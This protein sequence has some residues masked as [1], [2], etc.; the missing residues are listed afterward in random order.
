MA[1]VDIKARL[2]DSAVQRIWALAVF[3]ASAESMA[4]EVVAYQA[5][6]G[7]QFFGWFE[8]DSLLGICG[9]TVHEDYVEILHIAVA[10]QSQQRGI[11][12][13]MVTALRELHGLRLEAETDD[14][15]VEF[16]RR[17]G[18][19]TT[20]IC[21]YSIRRWVCVLAAPKPLDVVSDAERALLFP[22]ILREHN[23]AWAECFQEERSALEHL[24]GTSHIVR[25]RHIGSTAVAG[26]IAKPTID[27]LLEPTAD[28]S[29]EY[30]IA[31]LPQPEY[32]CLPH[33]ENPAPHLTFIKGYT[34]CGFAERVFHIHVRYAG[35]WDEPYFRDY[36]IAHPAIAAEYADLKQT[37]KSQFRYDRDG[38]TEAKGAFVRRI[39]ALAREES[40]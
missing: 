15:A 17:C 5:H 7:W 27:I 13:A 18:F 40:V 24:I 31:A 33:K 6:S 21:K 37:L 29:A 1:F 4:R 19:T 22:I 10:E 25:L 32:I 35:D 16:Y 12:R 3:D 39:T 23:P 8:E 28:S 30:L 36:L 11:G 38:Y 26:L 20:S 34:A 2:E 14:D 9:F